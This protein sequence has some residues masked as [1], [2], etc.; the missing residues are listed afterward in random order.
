MKNKSYKTEAVPKIDCE[1]QTESEKYTQVDSESQTDLTNDNITTVDKIEIVQGMETFPT[2]TDSEELRQMSPFKC[3]NEMNHGNMEGGNKSPEMDN[4]SESE[5]NMSAVSKSDH[6]VAATV[7]AGL[8]MQVG[9]Y[10]ELSFSIC[11][12]CSSETNANATTSA[13]EI[14]IPHRPMY[15]TFKGSEQRT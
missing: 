2:Q 4:T 3:A 7:S 6:K 9:A 12:K 1:C 11:S 5:S 14:T 15:K 13:R 10:K 8:D